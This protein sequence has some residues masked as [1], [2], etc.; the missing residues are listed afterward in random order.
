MPRIEWDESFSID[1]P[2]IDKQHRKWIEIFNKMHEC[3][4]NNDSGEYK[5]IAYVTLV[6]MQ[7]YA[8]THFKFEEEY[9]YRIN[10]PDFIKHRRLHKD[11]DTKIYEYNRD[12]RDG[13]M[14][15]NTEI[16]KAIKNWLI[17]HILKED[18]KIGQFA[19]E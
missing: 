8:N 12:I 13:K 6:S 7:E 19:A 14:V 3:M 1:H 5:S 11:F 9:M 2:A 18:K 16:L 10:Y 15:L 17:N 4:L